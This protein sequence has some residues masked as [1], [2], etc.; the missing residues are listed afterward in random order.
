[1]SVQHDSSSVLAMATD[2]IEYTV[3]L[4]LTD[5]F[6]MD[7]WFQR[8]GVAVR[9]AHRADRLITILRSSAT[10]RIMVE[11]LPSIK[12]RGQTDRVAIV[13]DCNSNLSF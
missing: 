4:G 5:Q 7:V 2:R 11:K 1:M 3:F 9:K 10:G 8:S 12:D 13:A 6:N